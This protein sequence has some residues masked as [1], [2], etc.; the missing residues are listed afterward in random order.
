MQMKTII[1]VAALACAS[2]ASASTNYVE[3]AKKNWSLIAT[4]QQ[5][6]KDP[7][8]ADRAAFLKTLKIVDACMATDGS[9]RG[10]Q[11][12]P[13]CCPLTARVS[14]AGCEVLSDRAR[15]DAL[16]NCG[17]DAEARS[18]EPKPDEAGYANFMLQAAAGGLANPLN[19]RSA[20]LAAAVIP[21]RRTIRREGGTFVGKEGGAK[22]KAILDALANELNSPRF[23]NAGE[24]LAEIGI[25]VEWEAVQSQ[26]LGDAEIA[27]L[28]GRLLDGEIPF[29]PSLQNKLCVA[30]GVDAY[31]DFVSEYN[32]K[33]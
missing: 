12:V 30:L 13:R 4:V 31:N 5:M 8:L 2:A 18:L 23:G 7:E 6:A 22:V 24:L 27:A 25:E 29:G 14:L 21:T 15:A 26:I 32:G 20:V 19:V 11:T 28:K 16:A 17:Y 3:V 10:Y 9:R 1:A 33:K